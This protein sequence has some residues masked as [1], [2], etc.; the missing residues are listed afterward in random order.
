MEKM[1][2]EEITREL[3]EKPYL[4][5]FMLAVK[6]AN[7]SKENLQIITAYMQALARKK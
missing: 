1:S 6:N 2:V 5:D 7:L 4:L 3:E